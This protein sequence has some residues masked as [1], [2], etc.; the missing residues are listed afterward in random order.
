M[1][2]FQFSLAG[3][4]VALTSI[5]FLFGEFHWLGGSA[6]DLLSLGAL[7]WATAIVVAIC[8][9]GWLL[10]FALRALATRIARLL[11]SHSDVDPT[12]PRPSI[13]L[14]GLSAVMVAIF[15]VVGFY[16]FPDETHSAFVRWFLFPVSLALPPCSLLLPGCWLGKKL[17]QSLTGRLPPDELEDAEPIR[18]DLPRTEGSEN[19]E[20]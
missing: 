2:R 19:R 17:A 13:K 5:A 3:L 10:L 14:S 4:F 18:F 20:G 16:F 7:A 1:R 8:A 9:V 15:V 12:G 6:K 11:S